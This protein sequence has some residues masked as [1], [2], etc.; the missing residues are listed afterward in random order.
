MRIRLIVTATDA[1]ALRAGSQF[2]PAV[3]SGCEGKVD[4]HTPALGDQV[5]GHA[6]ENFVEFARAAAW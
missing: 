4:L 5:S 6:L 3:R 2:Q 1:R